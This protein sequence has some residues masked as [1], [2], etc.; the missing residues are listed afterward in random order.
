MA[1]ARSVAR[2]ALLPADVGHV[3]RAL[4]ERLVRADVIEAFALRVGAHLRASRSTGLEHGFLAY[5]PH[6]PDAT[7]VPE[8]DAVGGESDIRWPWTMPHA[9]V[10][11][12]FHTHPGPRAMCVPSG[13]DLAGALVRGEHVTYVLTMDGRLSGWRF[14]EP[15]RHAWAVDDALT[16]LDKAREL[17]RGFLDFLH[18]A[19]DALRP[20][21]VE[22]VYAARVQ[23]DEDERAPGVWVV[24]EDPGAGFFAPEER[25]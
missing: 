8:E 10:A 1:R 18:D 6:A 25:G 23:V 17:K 11:F 13:V 7:P 3:T 20:T 24:R 2:P 9:T 5:L 15:A 14:R 16:H 19:L 12:S 4:P 22:C 21:L